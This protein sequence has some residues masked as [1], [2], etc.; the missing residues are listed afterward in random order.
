[1]RGAA[2]ENSD[3]D[4]QCGHGAKYFYFKKKDEKILAVP[5]SAYLMRTDKNNTPY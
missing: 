5:G 3:H 1:M 4:S 2:A